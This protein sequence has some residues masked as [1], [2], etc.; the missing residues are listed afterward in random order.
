[1]MAASAGGDEGDPDG[2]GD[3]VAVGTGVVG[4]GV[5]GSVGDVPGET[6]GVGDGVRAGKPSQPVSA[7]PST[8]AARRIDSRCRTM[9][10]V[11]FCAEI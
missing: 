7:A 9:S 8:A 3:L 5:V 10:V 1:M 11:P 4:S 2:V 6:G